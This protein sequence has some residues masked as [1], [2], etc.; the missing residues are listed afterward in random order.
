M[1]LPFLQLE[2]DLLAHGGPEVAS[3]A[4]C[5]LAQVIGH[6]SLLRAWAVSHAG[7]DAPP[8]GWV[9]G[10]AS[11]RRIEAAAQW[12]GERGVLLKALIDAGQVEAC[13]GGHR[14]MNLEP[15]AK[16]WEQG[17]VRFPRVRLKEGPHI[18][19]VEVRLLTPEERAE[20]EREWQEAQARRRAEVEKRQ[21][22]E[23]AAKRAASRVYFIRQDM[24]D[25]LVKIGFTRRPVEK[26]LAELQKH[27]ACVLVVA[28]VA[29]GLMSE[30]RHLHDRFSHL[31]VS[32][33]WF[34]AEA[35]L[36]AYIQLVSDR[37]TL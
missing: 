14:V 20:K 4:G 9:P 18:A 33:E 26:R 10:E 3:L 21:R 32:G 6:L 1:R 28:A 29:P 12:A 8:D 16:V 24:P 35:D 31:R 25:G 36:T 34:R 2:S 15:Y 19:P 13:E 7:D 11:G 30:E 22:E 37:G 5:T 27:H 23:E 17:C